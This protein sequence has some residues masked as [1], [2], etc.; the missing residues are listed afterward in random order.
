MNPQ[1]HATT[2]LD[3][4]LHKTIV[5]QK[6]YDTDRKTRPYLCTSTFIGCIMETEP[7]LILSAIQLGFISVYT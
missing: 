6:L 7:T 1:Q 4:H 2:L 5:F 3:L